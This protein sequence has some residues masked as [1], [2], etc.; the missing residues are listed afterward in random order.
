MTEFIFRSLR[1]YDDYHLY[2]LCKPITVHLYDSY[3]INHH[4][5][6]DKLLKLLKLKYNYIALAYDNNVVLSV[7]NADIVTLQLICQ[8][9]MFANRSQSFLSSIKIDCIHNNNEQYY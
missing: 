9:N 5:F 8:S 4:L 1:L 2:E 7:M 6:V 3:R